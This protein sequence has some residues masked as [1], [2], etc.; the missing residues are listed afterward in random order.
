MADLDARKSTE[1]TM[2]RAF[3]RL[4]RVAKISS[5]AAILFLIGYVQADELRERKVKVDQSTFKCIL[6][7]TAVRGFFVDNLSGN[8][9]GAVAVAQAG[10]GEYPE[11]SVLQLIPNEV[12]IK[13]QKGFSPKTNDWE[14]FALDTNRDGSKIVSRGADEVNN[15]LGL[16][17]FECH[18]AARAEFDLVCEEDH[19]CVPLP[20]THAM[21]HAVQHTDPRCQPPETLSAEDAAALKDLGPVIEQLKNE[22]AANKK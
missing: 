14:F 8:L 4:S 16:N 22:A 12:M 10:K 6:Q 2:K 18:K 9:D 13:Q 21:F 20:L 5:S 11:G 19:G 3:T 17:C 1:K 7:M 15:F